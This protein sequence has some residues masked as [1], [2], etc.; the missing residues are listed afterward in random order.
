M[1][2][3][4]VRDTV[5]QAVEQAYEDWASE[6]PSLA[7]V[8]D[9]TAFARRAAESL[10]NSDDYRQAVAGYHRGMSE[11][12]LLARLTELVSPILSALLVG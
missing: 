6:H 7:A 8:I 2:D 1:T 10:R 11:S 3:E 5:A 12:D 9:R 4:I